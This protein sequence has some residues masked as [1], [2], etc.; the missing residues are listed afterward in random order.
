MIVQSDKPNALV[1][2]N[3][4]L[5]TTGIDLYAGVPLVL[6]D[7]EVIG[8]LTLLAYEPRA[9]LPDDIER[10]TAAATDLVAR[11]GTADA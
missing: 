4:Y 9:F 2:E 1:G 11:F 10:L 3:A 6:G 5:Q 8:A 7:G